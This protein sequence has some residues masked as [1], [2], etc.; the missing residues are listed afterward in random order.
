M[1][2]FPDEATIASDELQMAMYEPGKGTWI[3][4]ECSVE[5]SG[6]YH[7]LF[8]YD[9][10]A[11]FGDREPLEGSWINELR[12][13]PRPWALIPQWHPVKQKFTEQEWAA[14]VARDQSEQPGA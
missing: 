4:M 6:A 13:H 5:L 10:P 14:D 3:S 11:T 8:N 12:R 2:F 9:Q 7:F 1:R